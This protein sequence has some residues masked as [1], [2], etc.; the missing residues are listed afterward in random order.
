M[1]IPVIEARD[2]SFRVRGKP[3]VENATLSLE[4]GRVAV[5]I[6]P[7]GAGKSTLLRLLSGELTPDDGQIE[8]FGQPLRSIPAWRLACRRAVMAQ[9][10]RLNFPFLVHEVVR[11]GIE[12]LGRSRTRALVD[13]MVEDALHQADM[14]AFAAR[15]FQS[16]SGGEQQRVQFARVLCQLLA[17]RSVEP[18][19]VLFLDEPIASLD[20]CHQISLLAAARDL[21]RNNNVAVLAILH[22]L[23]L[24]AAF[25][26]DLIAMHRARVIATGPPDIVLTRELL[27]DV[28]S[29]DMKNGFELFPGLGPIILPQLCAVATRPQKRASIG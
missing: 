25:A 20:L 22:D 28:F 2:V 8:S 19:Q 24:S 26:D 17:G 21:A 15:D 11:L 13:E 4:P 7:N 23:N 14:L 18:T 29:I 27:R 9:A 16:L 12:G 3:L 1:V 5:I 6:G 10:A